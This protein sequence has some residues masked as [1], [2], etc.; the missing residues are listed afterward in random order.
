MGFNAEAAGFISVEAMVG[1]M[2]QSEDQQLAG[3]AT[4]LRTNKLHPL[5][6]VHDWSGFSRAYNGPEFQKNQYDARLAAACAGFASGLLPDILVRQAQMFLMF[7][8]F[9]IGSID[10]IA[11]KRTRSAVRQFR[12]EHRLGDSDVIDDGLI[13]CAANRLAR[14]AGT[15]SHELIGFSRTIGFQT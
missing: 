5:L 12:Q 13:I 2:Q 11:G 1:A 9:E 4:Y 15:F 3:M 6:A 8:G 10:G 7:L 14:R